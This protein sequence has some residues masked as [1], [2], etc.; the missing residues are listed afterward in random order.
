MVQVYPSILA[1]DLGALRSEIEKVESASGIHFDVMDG[2]FVPNISFGPQTVESLREHTDLYFDTHLMIERPRRYVE[3]FARA[4]ADRLT[5]HIEGSHKIDATLEDINRYG[6]DAGVAINPTTPVDEVSDYLDSID[7]LLI[8]GVEPGFSGQKFQPETVEKINR[9]NSLTGV[10]IQIDG[11]IDQETGPR[12]AAA[13]ADSFVAGS[14]IFSCPDTE[15]A[16]I[17]LKE[18]IERGT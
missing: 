8:M 14:A 3:A 15:Q 10:E 12:C 13:G 9:A 4:G 5:V 11:G 16:L 7:T 6:I 18:Y 17:R 1:G 2:H